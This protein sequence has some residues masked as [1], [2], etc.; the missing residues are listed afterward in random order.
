M[1]ML[2]EALALQSAI[3]D[4]MVELW[5]VPICLRSRATRPQASAVAD[6]N[7]NKDFINAV[8]KF[9]LRVGRGRA[10]ELVSMVAGPDRTTSLLHQSERST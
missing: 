5:S 4:L 10:W 8:Q 7:E 3:A 6:S 1:G 9:V 2:I